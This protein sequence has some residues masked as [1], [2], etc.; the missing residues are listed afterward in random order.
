MYGDPSVV[1]V[2]FRPPEPGLYVVVLCLTRPP[3]VPDQ[4]RVS[5]VGAPSTALVSSSVEGKRLVAIVRAEAGYLGLSPRDCYR[6]E[7]RTQRVISLW[8]F[9]GV[10]VKRLRY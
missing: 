4:F 10:S 8:Q 3:Y 2:D 5:T 7:F 6:L 9:G 1:Y